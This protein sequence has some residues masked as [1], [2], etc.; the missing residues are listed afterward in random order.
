MFVMPLINLDKAKAFIKRQFSGRNTR[1]VDSRT[2]SDTCCDCQ[3]S[4]ANVPF[5]SNC[6]HTFCYYCLKSNLLVDSG[7]CCP[8]CG[9]QIKTIKRKQYDAYTDE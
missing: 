3:A 7:Y 9:C 4:P 6:N 5:I 2:E 1:T 8:A